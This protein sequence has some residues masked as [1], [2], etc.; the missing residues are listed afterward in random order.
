MGKEAECEASFSWV[1]RGKRVRGKALLETDTIVFR[2]DVKVTL[3]RADIEEAGSHDG[4][5]HLRTKAG[6]AQLTLGAAQA[7]RWAKAILEPPTLISKLGVKAGMRVAVLGD[8][9]EAFLD[10]LAE[11]AEDVAG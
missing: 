6:D 9:D 1:S 8:L 5:L 10:A 3:A 2:G 4:V 7:D 11:V